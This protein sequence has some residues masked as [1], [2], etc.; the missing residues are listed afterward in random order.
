MASVGIC[1]RLFHEIFRPIA[2][3]LERCDL[4]CI[5]CIFGTQPAFFAIGMVE[6]MYCG[7]IAKVK[8]HDGI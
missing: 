6:A 8:C 5:M 1:P 3:G 7:A 4:L 2:T